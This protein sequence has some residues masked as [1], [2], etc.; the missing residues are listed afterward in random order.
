MK[1]SFTMVRDVLG[2]YILAKCMV[3][4]FNYAMS[5][6]L[7]QCTIATPVSEGLFIAIITVVGTIV[8]SLNLADG[9]KGHEK[10]H[11]EDP[12]G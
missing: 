11:P 1:A 7:A 9:Y 2:Y 3:G 6:H 10:K 12:T 4:G 8:T 5:L